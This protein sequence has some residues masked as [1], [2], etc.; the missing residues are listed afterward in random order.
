MWKTPLNTDPSYKW[1]ADNCSPQVQWL[2]VQSEASD[3][4]L[5][6]PTNID[7]KEMEHKGVGLGEWG[8]TFPVISQKTI[9]K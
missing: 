5:L 9:L 3:C 7:E 8:V 4:H 2:N 6:V 1:R